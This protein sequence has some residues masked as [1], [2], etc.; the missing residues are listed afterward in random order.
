[1]VEQARAAR[2]CLDFAISADL[3]EP[4]RINVYEHWES[5][6]DLERFRG[7]G[8]EPAQMAEIRDAEVLRY[9]ISSSGPA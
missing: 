8:P 9:G 6:A 3:L 1:V 5:D 7:T 4:G 2:G